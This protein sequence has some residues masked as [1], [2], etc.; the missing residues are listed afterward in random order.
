MLSG[1][2]E[3]AVIDLFRGPSGPNLTESVEA[4]RLAVSTPEGH[5]RDAE[6]MR[7]SLLSNGFGACQFA[8]LAASRQ[9]FGLLVA[10]K[11]D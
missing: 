8:F 4:L 5:I 9:G 1:G 10:A 2:G 6:A 11:K 7:K 3:L